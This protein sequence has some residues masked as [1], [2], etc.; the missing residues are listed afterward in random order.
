MNFAEHF[1]TIPSYLERAGDLRL[2]WFANDHRAKLHANNPG[3]LYDADLA[4]LDAA[5]VGFT[6]SYDDEDLDITTRESKTVT[7]NKWREKALDFFS[8]TKN[9]IAYTFRANRDI[10]EKFYPHGMKEYHD[11]G[12]EELDRLLQR[13]LEVALEHE[14]RL[15]P[16]LVAELQGIVTGY[17]E[18]LTSQTAQKGEVSESRLASDLGRITLEDQLMKNLHAI[19]RNNLRHPEVVKAYF[20]LS[21][22]MPRKHGA[23]D[24]VVSGSVES[25]ATEVVVQGD[26]SAGTEAVIF[27]RGKGDLLFYAVEHPADPPPGDA[28]PVLPGSLVRLALHE[29]AHPG[30]RCLMVHNPDEHHT[31]RYRVEVVNPP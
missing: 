22:V 19:A 7:L 26:F 17:H 23:D 20:D 10:Y 2:L 16:G 27:N 5:L 21:I 9:L 3:G 6:G 28:L 8:Q 30:R 24:H 12:H 15:P 29:N 31:G 11:A 13:Y 18:A 25:L 4:A 14:S 1:F